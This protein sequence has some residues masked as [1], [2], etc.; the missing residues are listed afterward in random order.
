V[1]VSIMGLFSPDWKNK[2]WH[3]RLKAIESGKLDD[4]ILLYMAKNDSEQSIRYKAADCIRSQ[5]KF[6]EAIISIKKYNN[7]GDRYELHYRYVDNMLKQHITNPELLERIILAKCDASSTAFSQLNDIEILK[8]IA[9]K[10]SMYDAEMKIVRIINDPKMWIQ[11]GKQYGFTEE[12]L[13]HIK[14]T[15]AYMDIL[16]NIALTDESKNNRYDATKKI[17]DDERLLK[18]I[19]SDN[20]DGIRATAVDRLG[21][22]ESA[23][24]IFDEDFSA[25]VKMKAA[26]KVLFTKK[27]LEQ[28]DYDKLI[29]WMINNNTA[30]TLNPSPDYVGSDVFAL[31]VKLI[32]Q[33]LLLSYGITLKDYHHEE[34]GD[35]GKILTDDGYSVFY[36]GKNVATVDKIKT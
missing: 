33:N 13:S 28:I 25:W 1:G 29:P 31:I 10:D 20:D 18:I 2:D 36:N 6:A 11:Y 8:R 14:D 22:Y 3:K 12:I 32:P 34:V 4:D 5:E 7:L 19:Y 9:Q 26:Q 16:L 17:V 35:N 30:G 24:K 15:D 27:Q 23:M 21:S